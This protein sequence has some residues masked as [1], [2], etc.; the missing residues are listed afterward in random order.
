MLSALIP[1][2]ARHALSQG[3]LD[4]LRAVPGDAIK[5]ALFALL[6]TAGGDA[7]EATGWK[8][9]TRA[10]PLTEHNHL[11]LPTNV[12]SPVLTVPLDDKC[13]LAV[14]LD[15]PPTLRVANCGPERDDTSK[16]GGDVQATAEGLS[17]AVTSPHVQ[18]RSRHMRFSNESQPAEEAV[19][20]MAIDIESVCLTRRVGS[21]GFSTTYKATMR[22][23]VERREAGVNA[24]A[25]KLQGEVAFVDGDAAAAAAAADGQTEERVVAVKVASSAV[26]SLEQWRVEIV[27]LASLNH[28]NI[29]RYL[30]Y[31][32]SPPNY[33]LVLEFCEAGDLHDALRRPTL[34]GFFEK[35]ST[36]VASG[37]A[38]L[39]SRR[40]IHRDVKSANVLMSSAPSADGLPYP[41]LTDF[42]VAVE[43][44]ERSSSAGNML[45]AETG[46]YRWMAPEVIRH[47]PYSTSADMYSCAI[48]L[49]ELLTHELP[50]RGY[51]PMQVAAAVALEDRRPPLPAGVPRP[52]AELLQRTWSTRPRERP[53]APSL[54]AELAGLKGLLTLAEVEWLDEPAGHPAPIETIDMSPLLPDGHSPNPD[55]LPPPTAIPAAEP[56]QPS[57][58][59]SL[60]GSQ[61]Q[62]CALQ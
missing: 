3:Q 36:G 35:I 61:K 32:D 51:E 20:P 14:S 25:A 16:V 46:T 10:T 34:P 42:G 1:R 4:S 55:Y 9:V 50:W 11:L 23:P 60:R 33:C 57:P 28:P 31:I 7:S 59:R 39:H 17:N 30:G 43:L 22:V 52:L 26:G 45:T 6:A 15:C 8:A 38:Y 47:Q 13:A 48:L 40:V 27:A 58:Q 5:H 2:N 56:A 12:R 21:G 49:Y 18:R 37:L 53:S 44:P 62:D 54:A 41:K 24:A 29:V 19:D